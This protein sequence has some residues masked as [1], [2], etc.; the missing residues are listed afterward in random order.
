MGGFD[1][2]RFDRSGFRVGL[3]D[4]LIRFV[5]FGLNGLIGFACLVV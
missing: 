3:F 2:I 5:W 1:M 4:W